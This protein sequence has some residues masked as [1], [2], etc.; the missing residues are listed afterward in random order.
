M[1]TNYKLLIN[2]NVCAIIKLGKVEI[3]K[4]IK[5]HQGCNK[6]LRI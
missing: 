2:L 6:I 4:R 3:I 5:R 1:R